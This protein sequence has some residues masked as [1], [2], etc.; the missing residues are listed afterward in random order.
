M[1]FNEPVTINQVAASALA[2]EGVM[3]RHL[4]QMFLRQTPHLVEVLPPNVDDSDI[5]ATSAALIELFAERRQE[6]APKWT[7]NIQR[8]GS[9]I[10]L[11]TCRPGTF[12]YRLCLEE[13][14]PPLR[15]RGLYAPENYLMFA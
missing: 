12:T 15:Q 11:L 1:R 6:T 3:T 8:Q 10:F 14:P 9:P 4:T 13:S 5:L 7:T 2:R